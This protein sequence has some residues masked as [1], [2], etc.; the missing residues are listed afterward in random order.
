MLKHRKPFFLLLIILVFFSCNSHQSEVAT[1]VKIEVDESSPTFTV[2]K[3]I[4]KIKDNLTCKWGG[5]PIDTIKA[6]SV[7]NE[8]T[9]IATTFMATMEVIKKAESEGLNM[10]ITHEPTFYNHFD[11]ME[12]LKNDAVQI[13]KLKYIDDHNIT[14][15]RFHDY[16]HKTRPDGINF[17]LIKTLGWQD[18]GNSDQM[19]FTLPERSVRQLAKEIAEKFKTTTV[20]VVG[21]PEMSISRV[22]IVPGAW[23]TAKQ[24]EMLNQPGIE[25]VIVGESR[26]WETVEYVRD[27]NELGMPKALIVMGHADSEDPG[28]AYCAEWLKEFI[29]EVP[30]K[31]IRA[32]NPLW[33]L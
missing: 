16:W 7:N 18:Y 26:E 28:M 1:E 31:Y 25:A 2:G 20:R 9:G 12:P 33:S 30:V 11:D 8:V 21:D 3:V 4:Q 22:G 24:I 27:M 15:W 19:I 29:V 10:I 6:G 32:G 5:G 13:A 23:G 17:G 14:I